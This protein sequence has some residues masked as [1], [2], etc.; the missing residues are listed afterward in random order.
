MITRIHDSPSV[1]GTN[2][3]WYIAVI[4]NCSRETLTSSRSGS[5][6]ILREEGG[7]LRGRIRRGDRIR[8][9]GAVEPLVLGMREPRPPDRDQRDGLD[10]QH[11]GD[12]LPQLEPWGARGGVVRHGGRLL[13]NAVHPP[14]SFKSGR[15]RA[16]HNARVRT[17]RA[18]PV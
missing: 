12:F 1:S 9:P 7:R 10:C 11:Q 16:G 5:M 14:I 8:D 13:E 17:D 18:V 2:R 6:V 4:A 3:K 15:L